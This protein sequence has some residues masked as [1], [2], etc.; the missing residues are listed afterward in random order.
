[1]IALALAKCEIM[2][3]RQPREIACRNQSPPCDIFEITRKLR[4]EGGFERAL[5]PHRDD[6]EIG[7]RCLPLG[8]AG[9]DLGRRRAANAD[10]LMLHA[11]TIGSAARRERWAT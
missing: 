5:L 1:M 4:P 10:R 7:A 11:T 9:V 3:A 2:P 8:N 6:A